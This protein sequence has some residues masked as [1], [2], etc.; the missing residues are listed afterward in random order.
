MVKMVKKWARIDEMDGG[1]EHVDQGLSR[2]TIMESAPP[3]AENKPEKMY[4]LEPRSP[5][6]VDHHRLL[7]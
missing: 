5:I 7:S 3:R 4:I 2:G 6:H 1:V